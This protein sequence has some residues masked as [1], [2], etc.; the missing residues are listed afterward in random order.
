MNAIPPIRYIDRISGRE[1]IEKTCAEGCL[2][3]LYNTSMVSRF[4]GRIV[5]HSLV[6][7]SPFSHFYGWW[8]TLPHT[9]KKIKPF[10]KAFNIDVSEIKKSIDEFSSFNDFF[11]RKLKEKARPIHSDNK[12]VIIPADARYRFFQRIDQAEGFIVKGEK[13]S[14]FSLLQDKQLAHRYSEGSMVIARLHPSDYHRFHFPCDGTPEP[15]RRINGFLYSVNP[16]AVKKNIHI[17]T[18]NKRMICKLHNQSFGQVLM[19]EI[20]AT[21]VGSINQ[22][23]QPNQPYKKGMEKGFFA[24]GGSAIILLFEKGKV[25]FDKDLLEASERNLE[26]RCLMGQSMGRV[27]T[28]A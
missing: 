4:F 16:I 2:K 3:F 25:A 6:K 13:F 7:T 10:I 15:P 8:Q 24:C 11:I 28:S 22:T 27:N 14:L 21:N 9:R 23:Y 18:K 26:I 1:C 17:F 5:L 20:G 19:V 12:G